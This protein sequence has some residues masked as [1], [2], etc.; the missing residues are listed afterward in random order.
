[1]F[2]FLV[3]LLAVAAACVSPKG[4]GPVESTGFLPASGLDQ[5]RPADIAVAPV[6]VTLLDG[7]QAPAD[8]VREALY[9]GLIDRLYSPLPLAWVD[10]GGDCDA[11]LQV[12]ILE[13]DP[14]MLNYDGTIMARA[15]A[16]LVAAG[17]SLWAVELTR[18]LNRNT[19]GPMRDDPAKAE[20]SSA[21]HLASEILALLPERNPQRE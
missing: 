20:V 5:A 12:R 9:L 19:S 13:W 1:M 14:S 11:V 18:R 10:G 21:Q 6:R 8:A 15:E 4:E 16:R 7:G 3:P 2:R 17:G